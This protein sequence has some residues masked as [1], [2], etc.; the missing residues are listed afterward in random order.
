MLEFSIIVPTYNRPRQLGECLDSLADLDYPHEAFEVIVV[1]DGSEQ[2][3]DEAVARQQTSLQ[4]TVLRQ[5]NG[6]PAA[7]RNTGLSRVD[8]EYVAFTDDD[9]R[10]DRSWL[11]VFNTAAHEFPGAMLGGHTINSIDR[12]SPEASQRIIDMVY[13]FYNANPTDSRLFTTNNMTLPMR[14]IRKIGLFE[15]AF[16]RQAGGEDRELCDRWRH[17]G[18]QLVYVPDARVFHSHEMTPAGFW[19]QHFN[20]GRGAFHYHRT[21]YRRA[22]S[23]PA[24]DLSFYRE[25]PSLARGVLKGLPGTRAL[26][27]LGMMAIWQVANASGFAWEALVSALR[28]APAQDDSR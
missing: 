12:L 15:T 13:G 22:A 17:S 24:E 10:P 8:S 1:D 11:R 5:E 9:C 7:A 21:R 28:P 26:G 2:P 20:Y 18:Y 23:H 27:V 19:R 3:V 25:L 6:G 16:Y 4:L 14:T